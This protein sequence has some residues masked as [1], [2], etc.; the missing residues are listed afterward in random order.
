MSSVEVF[1]SPQDHIGQAV[2]AV[3]VEAFVYKGQLVSSANVLFLKLS[4][5]WY[6]AAID[7]GT[8]HWRIQGE[9]PAPWSVPEEGW[10]YPHKD[11]GQEFGLAASV[12]SSVNLSEQGNSVRAEFCFCNGRRLV[13]FNA[14]DSSSYHVA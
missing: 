13:L 3:V 5:T 7:A 6:R 14:S 8:F 1:G 11:L 2:Q 4:G 12:L 9:A 10:S